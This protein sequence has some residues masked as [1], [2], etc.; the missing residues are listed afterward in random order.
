MTP[1]AR[2]PESRWRRSTWRMRRCGVPGVEVQREYRRFGMAL[3]RIPPSAVA[4]LWRSPVVDFVEPELP[5]TPSADGIVQPGRLFG[6]PPGQRQAV[7]GFS[8]SQDTPWGIAMV[9]APDAWGFVTGAT[10]RVMIISR[11]GMGL[12]HQD[13]PPMTGNNCGGYLGPCSSGHSYV[14]NWGAG[15]MFALNNSIGVVGVAPG[16]T[17]ANAYSWRAC[18]DPDTNGN[19]VCY[20]N[21]VITGLETAISLDI[22]TVVIYDMYWSTSN[23]GLANAIATAWAWEIVTVAGV[24]TTGPSTPNIYP[25]SYTQTVGVAGVLP[26]RSFA[27]TPDTT[28]NPC[29]IA[30]GYGI[31]KVD[32]SAPFYGRSTDWPTSYY[33]DEACGTRV[34]AAHVAGVLALIRE[35]FPS[36]GAASAYNRLLA[37]ASYA[38][39][40]DHFGAGIV[41]AL[42]AVSV[43]PP[44]PSFTAHINGLSTVPAYAQCTWF[45]S[46]NQGTAPYTYAWSVDGAPAGDGSTTFTYA[47]SGSPFV[48]ELLITD[49]TGAQAWTS[50]SVSIGGSTCADQ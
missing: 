20:I 33:W 5:T 35:R 12:G 22:R 44:P 36:Y 15:A 46:A 26:D 2:E 6:V 3:V 17:G 31:N 34:A 28:L 7:R 41:D 25:A 9:R 37:T 18:T 1:E 27:A 23:A 4:A 13:L 47:N 42:T 49:A 24:G 38:G 50:L 29:S 14:A 16:V 45:G 10:Q 32:V 8:L 39:A 21:Q 19:D 40:A 30:S 43:P 48:I 11:W